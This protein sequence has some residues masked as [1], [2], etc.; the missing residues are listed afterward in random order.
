MSFDR[1]PKPSRVEIS[2]SCNACEDC[3]P[4]LSFHPSRS[5]GWV[6]SDEYDE[7]SDW[8]DDQIATRDNDVE[9]L[10][11]R[12]ESLRET[13]SDLKFEV[14]DMTSERDFYLEQCT[15][16]ALLWNALP[17]RSYDPTLHVNILWYANLHDVIEERPLLSGTGEWFTL[18]TTEPFPPAPVVLLPAVC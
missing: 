7:L 16:L 13:V 14:A 15:K 17:A 6:S 11:T 1:K 4:S 9:L 3:D 8:A 2:A 12:I 5:S 10:E 18:N